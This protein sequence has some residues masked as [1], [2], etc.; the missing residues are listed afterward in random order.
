MVNTI[1]K[2]Y[3][4]EIK[5]ITQ[6]LLLLILGSMILTVASASPVEIT[7][8]SGETWIKWT[9]DQVASY[10][11]YVDG[12]LLLNDITNPNYII[13]G[14]LPPES[15]HQIRIIVGDTH[16]Y[17]ADSETWTTSPPVVSDNFSDNLNTFF[18]NPFVLLFISWFCICI[19][20]LSWIF[21]FPAVMFGSVAA[22]SETL[23]DNDPIIK[24]AFWMS[25][26]LIWVVVYFR[27][28][29]GD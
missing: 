1:F 2:R 12:N 11:I 29:R 6:V 20:F 28:I 9:W 5:M 21:I 4:Y 15:P 7:N 3:K 22:I 14:E 10:D 25:W 23:T 27:K 19:A 17:V 8:Q 24:L 16:A 26:V 13:V 18:L